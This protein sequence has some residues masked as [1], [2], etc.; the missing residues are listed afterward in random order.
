MDGNE[1][2]EQNYQRKIDN[3][4]LNNKGRDYLSGYYYFIN[5]LAISTVYA[6][7]N[8][9]LNFM[10]FTNKKPEDLKLNDYTKYLA[11]ISTKTPSYQIAVYSALKK[12]S[13]YL[14]ANKENLNYDMQYVSRP[15]F[16]EGTKTKEKREKGYLEKKEIKKYIQSVKEGAGSLRSM[17]RQELW[18]NRDLLIILIFLNTGMRCSALYKLNVSSIDLKEKKLVTIDKGRIVQQYD[19]PDNLIEVVEDWLI[20]RE[21]L[22]KDKEEEALFISNQRKRMDQSSISR[23]VSKYAEDISGKSIT[24]HKLRATYGTQLYGETKDLFFVQA[25]M[26]HSNPKT[27]ELYIRG[28]KSTN[29]EKAANIMKSIL[30]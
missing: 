1:M 12:F 15:K 19:L 22:L 10:E 8:D 3:I 30:Y 6:Y 25:S 24:P 9:V 4:L 18:K 29:R 5:N 23:V 17:A 20:T 26:G 27:T 16:R 13:F 21:V 14:Q 7:L 11:S 2:Y 28:Q